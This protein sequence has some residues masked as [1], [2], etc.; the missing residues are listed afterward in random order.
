[1]AFPGD[2]HAELRARVLRQ[3]EALESTSYED[4]EQRAVAAGLPGFR[5]GTDG[6][7]HLTASEYMAADDTLVNCRR[8]LRK[9]FNLTPLFTGNGKTLRQDGSEGVPETMVANGPVA[10]L[11]ELAIFPFSNDVV[12]GGNGA[13]S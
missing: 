6:H 13:A 10:D 8:F 1:M 9:V 12:L 2:E 5:E 3:R 11:N 7:G 4:I